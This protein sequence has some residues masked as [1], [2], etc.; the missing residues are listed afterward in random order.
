[1]KSEYEIELETLAAPDD[2]EEELSSLK[3]AAHM[4][5]EALRLIADVSIDDQTNGVILLSR[6]AGLSLAEI[7]SRMGMSK[8]AVH[9]RVMV[10][11]RQWP[12][13]ADVL[14]GTAAALDEA[15]AGNQKIIETRNELDRIRQEATRW[16]NKPN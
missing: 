5:R 6:M 15:I 2:D 12:P 14:T 13:L 16:M 7:G 9:K 11:S 8:Q 1:M 10:I 3:Q 4:L